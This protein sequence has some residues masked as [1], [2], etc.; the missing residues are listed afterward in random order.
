MAFLHK[1]HNEKQFVSQRLPADQRRQIT[2]A[3]SASIRTQQRAQRPA[4]SEAI[5]D[6][7]N[8]RSKASEQNARDTGAVIETTQEELTELLKLGGLD[9][10]RD[11][12]QHQLEVCMSYKKRMHAGCPRGAGRSEWLRQPFFPYLRAVRAL[13]LVYETGDLALS[14]AALKPYKIKRSFKLVR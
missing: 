12:R 6:N 5:A 7:E 9:E 13:H 11:N 2:A 1:V 8:K 14:L 10:S 3:L 4:E